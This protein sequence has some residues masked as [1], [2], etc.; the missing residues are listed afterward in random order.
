M[1]DQNNIDLDSKLLNEIL[2][3][4]IDASHKAGSIIMQNSTGADVMKT[5]ANSRDLL[6]EIDPLCEKTIRET[7]LAKFPNH[8]FLGEEDVPPGAEASAAALTAKLESNDWVWIVDPIDGTTNF[9]NGMPLCMPS[10]ACAYKGQVVVGVIYDCHRDELFT[11]IR[12]DGA[13][14]NSNPIKVGEQETLGDAII[15]MGS[16]PADESMKMSLKG[17]AALMPKVRTIRMLG[18]AALMLAWVGNGRLTSYWEYDLSSW[19]IAAGAL[20]IKEAGGQFTDFEGNDF[21]IRNRKICAT[22][23]RIHSELLKELKDAGIQ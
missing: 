14:L 13:K 5:K 2:E 3:V 10:V 6:T 12:G 19:D 15:A 18:S 20:I 1:T 16:P 11:A 23:G 9:A 21:D 7:I 22:N 4:A 17:V 8:A